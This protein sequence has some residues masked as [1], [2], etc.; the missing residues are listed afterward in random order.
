MNR[1]QH[2]RD[3][4]KELQ[5]ASMVGAERKRGSVEGME[6]KR[7]GK[8]GHV[9]PGGPCEDLQRLLQVRQEP[10]K[11]LSRGGLGSELYFNRMILAA[12][13]RIDC[14]GGGQSRETVVIQRAGAKVM[15]L[16]QKSE[17][18]MIVG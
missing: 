18:E 17:R 12:G 1:R 4:S 5:V 8:L 9:G 7:K 6:R 3:D 2:T 14:S 16:L 15:R 11:C 13:L 10:L